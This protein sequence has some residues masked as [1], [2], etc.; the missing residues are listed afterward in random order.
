M[1]IDFSINQKVKKWIKTLML[2]IARREKR[3]PTCVNHWIQNLNSQTLLKTWYWG[4]FY[5]DTKVEIQVELEILV[6]SCW[7]TSESISITSGL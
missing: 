2:F 3:Q 5:L 1:L 4:V 7:W 6:S